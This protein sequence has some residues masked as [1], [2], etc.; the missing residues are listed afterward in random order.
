MSI[1]RSNMVD[2]PSQNRYRGGN[3]HVTNIKYIVISLTTVCR[4]TCW[5]LSERFGSI[6]HVT[7]FTGVKRYYNLS[8]FADVVMIQ[9]L[10]SGRLT[11]QNTFTIHQVIIGEFSTIL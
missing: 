8:K 2:L 10:C 7:K 5:P 9:T 1:I 4:E 11:D 6:G 3:E